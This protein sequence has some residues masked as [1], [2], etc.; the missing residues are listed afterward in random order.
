MGVHSSAVVEPGAVL[1]QDV[2]IGPFAVIGPEVELGA[3]VRVGAHAVLMGRTTI[4]ARTRVFPHACLGGEGQV[5]GESDETTRL[6][7]GADNVLREH[8]TIHR[9]SRKGSGV[10]RLGDRNYL[11]NGCH[12]GHDCVVGSDCVMAS[13]CALG[14]HVEVAD[15]AV[16]GAYTGVHQ[17]CRVGE[18][19]MTAAGSKF[20]K[21][22][23]PFVTV[24]GDRARLVGLNLVGLKRRGFT[25]SE[26]ASLKHA[27]RTLF[28]SGLR[29][30][31]AA[32]ALE[33]DGVDTPH[34]RT[35]IEFIRSSER[36][37]IR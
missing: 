18:S 23:A 16:L 25:A 24:A 19:A 27:Y 10:T 3:G 21:D 28:G 6:E 2:E 29:V 33:T 30:D 22:A 17:W 31:E 37:V 9:G 35:L 36:G 4:G 5:L 14:G 13:F 32:A 15:H 1:G 7:V 12:V 34:V 26:L 11:M 20:T 8:V